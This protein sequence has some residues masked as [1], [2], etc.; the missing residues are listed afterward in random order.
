MRDI[1]SYDPASLEAKWQTRWT[2]RHTNELFAE[3]LGQEGDFC[4]GPLLL[5][6][7][8]VPEL[9]D[10]PL[11]LGWGWRF[12][13]LAL[14]HRAGWSVVPVP[15]EF[16]CPLDQRGED[17]LPSRLYRLEQMSQNVAAMAYGWKAPLPERR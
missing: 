13:A 7:E 12:V 4:Y 8:L 6:P 16:P 5:K 10:V 1:P 17:D 11:E 9:L 3:L 15:G 14:S 2:E